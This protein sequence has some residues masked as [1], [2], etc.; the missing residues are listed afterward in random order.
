MG[1]LL[2]TACLA[3]CKSQGAPRSQTW[4]DK[5]LFTPLFKP[6]VFVFA[7][8]PSEEACRGEKSCLFKSMWDYWLWE[9]WIT[10]YEICGAISFIFLCQLRLYVFQ[11]KV[12]I[13]LSCV[14]EGFY[15]VLL[16]SSRNV[17]W[18]TKPHPIYPND[19]IFHIWADLFFK[20]TTMSHNV[21]CS[22]PDGGF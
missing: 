13:C 22:D 15:T 11:K 4:F 19:W 8:N 10:P 9:T 7:C 3:C 17:L 1:K 12:S 6:E 2:H 16:R 14:G 5:T 20:T 21:S 18:T